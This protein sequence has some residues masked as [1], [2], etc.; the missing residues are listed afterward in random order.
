MRTLVIGDI[1]GGLKA[2]VQLLA[3]LKLSQKDTLIFLGDYVDGWGQSAQV[4]SFLLEFSKKQ[5]C[6]F[7]KGNHDLWCER[8]LRDSSTEQAWLAH[9]GAATI[10]SYETVSN[11]EK[12]KHLRFLEDMPLYYLDNQRRLFLHAGF[13]AENGVEEEDVPQNLFYD[14][15]LWQIAMQAEANEISSDEPYLRRFKNYNE[16][17]IGHTPT[18][19]FDQDTPMKAL[20]V[21]NIDTGAAFTGKL[22]AIDV[23]SK[24]IFQSEPVT[25]FYPS[26]NG[27]N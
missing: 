26:E 4:L 13:T 1:H 24:K 7:I 27:R 6:I 14:R 12:T 5:E 15:T 2:L 3:K 9:G 22:S 20:N 19:R 23:N 8:W 11:A 16:I 10:K 18:L 21:W 17:F 25:D